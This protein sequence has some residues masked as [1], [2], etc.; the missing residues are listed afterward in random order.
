[1]L[2]YH[3]VW[4]T[5]IGQSITC[6]TLPAFEL[7]QK[8]VA[9]DDSLPQAH[10]VLSRAYLAKKQLEQ[11]IAEAERAITLDPNNADGYAV[12]AEMLNWVGRHEEAIGLVEKAM[13]LNPYYPW[14]YLYPLGFAYAA[15]GW[16]EEAI[17]TFRRGLTRNPDFQPAHLLLAAIYSGSGREAE[18]RAEAAEVLRISPN[19]SLE[20][21]RQTLPL[22]DQERIY[23][24]TPASAFHGCSRKR[25]E[26]LSPSVIVGL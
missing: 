4:A 8:A 18:A 14:G 21:A 20:V 1:M 15:T 19:F 6:I 23:R 17:A 22:T 12:L 2:N 9:L 16:I 26:V 13:R 7:A 3:G 11:A 10:M 25:T 24:G 5:R